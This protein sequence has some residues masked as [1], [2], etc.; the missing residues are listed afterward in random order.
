ML[1]ALV[2]QASRQGDR[3]PLTPGTV[4]HVWEVL[5]YALHH[6]A[7]ATNPTERVDFSAS[8]DRR[9]AI[10]KHSNT[11]RSPP[12]RSAGWRGNSW[13]GAGTP[14]ISMR[15]VLDVAIAAGLRVRYQRYRNRCTIEEA[16]ATQP[17]NRNGGAWRSDIGG[18]SCRR[19]R[20]CTPAWPRGPG[21]PELATTQTC[22]RVCVGRGR[23]TGWA[24]HRNRGRRSCVPITC[25]AE[26]N[27]P[28]VFPYQ[29]RSHMVERTAI[30][31]RCWGH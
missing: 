13:R 30:R 12:S 5:R 10:G 25:N 31:N 11:A 22:P 1:T 24:H 3:K 14:G 26:Q 15:W 21:M 7:I 16:D 8:R 6:G 27:A 18:G 28:R 9:S 2:R 29:R 20:G 17:L 19:A 4:K 23:A